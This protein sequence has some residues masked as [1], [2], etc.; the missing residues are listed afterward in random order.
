MPATSDTALRYASDSGFPF[1]IAVQ[2]AVEEAVSHTGWRVRYVEHGWVHPENGQ[3]GFID[4]VLE[5]KHSNIQLVV[6]C[7][8]QRD[9][10]WVFMHYSGNASARRHARVWVTDFDAVR[11]IQHGWVHAPFDPACPEATFCALRGQNANE[12]STLLERTG[13]ELIVATESLAHSERDIGQKGTPSRR[14]YIPIIVTTANLKIAHF[15]PASVSLGDGE[16]NKAE[17]QDVKCVRFRKQ[18][19]AQF[20]KLSAGDLARRG[21]PSYRMENTIV[22]VHSTALIGFLQDFEPP[23]QYAG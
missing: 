10:T 22:V 7:K 15:E 4:L 11:Q 6:E 12:R 13:A 14:Y 20:T 18:L 17:V 9:T 23:E 8:R 21:D 3:R 2:H 19:N 16:L 1:Q 5:H